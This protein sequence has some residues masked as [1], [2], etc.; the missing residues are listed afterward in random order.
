MYSLFGNIIDN[1]IECV[2]QYEEPEKRQIALRIG[3]QGGLISIRQ[4]NY[5]GEG[6]TFEDGLPQTTKADK[7]YHG[8]GTKSIR[9]V[10]EKYEGIMRYHQ[11][12]DAFI[13]DIL[14]DNRMKSV[15]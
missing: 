1:A 13:I 12:K 6:L 5:C 4:E 15:S 14:F 8:F 10:V 3:Q 9:Y 11:E 2:R 7:A